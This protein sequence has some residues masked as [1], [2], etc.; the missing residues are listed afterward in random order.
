MFRVNVPTLGF[1][2]PFVLR[3]TLAMAARHL[4]RLQPENKSEHYSA[5]AEKHFS[6]TLAEVLH[7]LPNLDSENCQALYISAI[8]ICIYFFARGPAP[9]EY[10]VFGKNG[11]SQFLPLL[12][13]VR[14]IMESLGPDIVFSGPLAPMHAGPS[15][16]HAENST[17]ERDCLP[18]VRW[19]EPV[20][21]LH[22][23]I[24]SL[25]DRD[26]VNICLPALNSLSEIFEATYG[27]D[28]RSYQGDV[29]NQIVLRWLYC[30]NGDFILYLQHKQPIAL[31]ICAYFALI[32]KVLDL[33]QCW[34][35]NGW[36][37]H[38]LIGV[39][40]SL[41]PEYQV[42]LHWPMEQAGVV[43]TSGQIQP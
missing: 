22:Q 41:G 40:A 27:K 35:M 10:L 8:F 19:Q 14:T 7:L 16:K 5:L 1:T 39:R 33:Q 13:G 30:L 4:Q 9:G 23:F 29:N 38:I 25:E 6:V 28:D 21:K 32:M 11:P 12:R 31:I 20:Q 3:L 17:A 37:E 43:D 15:P 26:A 36:A 24:S 2:Y 42:W 34:F 18:E